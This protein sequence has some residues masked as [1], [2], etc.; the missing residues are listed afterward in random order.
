MKLLGVILVIIATLS[1]V[2]RAQNENI[3]GIVQ[4]ANGVLVVWNEPGNNFTLE[5]KGSNFENIP[6]QNVAFMLGGKF[7]Q[8]VTASTNEI[9]ADSQGQQKPG[10][11]EILIAHQVWETKYIKDETGMKP[12][13]NSEFLKLSNGKTALLWS[14]R[15]S[16]K[17]GEKVERQ[18][19]L[20]VVKGEQVLVLNGK[21]TPATTE[22]A[23]RAFLLDT[24]QTLRT[25][26]GPLS[27]DDAQRLA[28]TPN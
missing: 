14:Y 15:M 25:S 4:T 27:Q 10:D 22:P 20:T 5:A 11:N 19:F 24:L 16:D 18:V 1:T 9:L 8:V 17:P 6:N 3:R 23:V 21:I 2:S 26:T 12:K 13:I 7:L 28:R